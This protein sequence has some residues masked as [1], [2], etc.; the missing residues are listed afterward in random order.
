LTLD[1]NRLELEGFAAGFEGAKSELMEP[2]NGK[3]TDLRQFK[4]TTAGLCC[5][6]EVP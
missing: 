6:A 1:D 5:I 3:P 4:R 2:A